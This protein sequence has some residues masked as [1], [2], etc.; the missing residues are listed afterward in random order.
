MRRKVL[1]QEMKLKDEPNE[2]IASAG[3]FIIGQVRNRFSFEHDK[4][5]VRMI[6]ESED[7]Q[8]RALSASRRTDD[9]VNSSRCNIERNSAERVHA[10]FIFAQVAFD[11]ATTQSNVWRH[12]LE[13]RKVVTG[14][15]W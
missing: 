13:P 4:T 1:H 14:G 11:I 9:G 6:K 8:E 15:S 2:F 7:I 3:K 5:A 12:T 10:R